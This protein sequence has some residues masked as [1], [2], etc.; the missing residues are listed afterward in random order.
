MS[1]PNALVQKR[2]NY[3]NIL[4]DDWLSY[5]NYVEQLTFLLFLKMA[6]EQAKRPFNPGKS[7]S[8]IPKGFG[9]DALLKLEAVASANLQRA[10]R[11]RQSILQKAFSGRLATADAFG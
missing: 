2:W 11:L 10:T 1:N 9:W 3:C 8:P 7:E 6:D 5:G 4:R